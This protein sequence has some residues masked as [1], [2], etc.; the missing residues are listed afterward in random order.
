[1]LY[2][3]TSATD[4]SFVFDTIGYAGNDSFFPAALAGWTGSTGDKPASGVYGYTTNYAGFGVIGLN[5]AAGTGVMG[6]GRT[7]VTGRGSRGYGLEATQSGAASLFL[8]T[9]NDSGPKNPPLTRSDAHVVGHSVHRVREPGHHLRQLVVG[10][11]CI[12]VGRS[13]LVLSGC[14]SS[15]GHPASRT[16]TTST[17][18]F[19]PTVS[20]TGGGGTF[21]GPSASSEPDEQLPTPIAG[22]PSQ[23][24]APQSPGTISSPLPAHCSAN[25]FAHVWSPSRLVVM[26]SCVT[27]S[28]TVVGSSLSH[29][30]DGEPI[31]AGPLDLLLD[32][33]FIDAKQRADLDAVDKQMRLQLKARARS[34]EE[35]SPFRTISALNRN[36]C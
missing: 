3:G 1:V 16:A 2:S 22:I 36:A 8:R 13:V 7:G 25:P 14:G 33:G 28:G 19:Q 24:V 5:D 23:S 31:G 29:D 35:P 6:I 15:S 12:V 18:S 26:N 34:E 4:T 20:G 27:V 17:V 9:V 10:G 21:A 32:A 30:G 11:G